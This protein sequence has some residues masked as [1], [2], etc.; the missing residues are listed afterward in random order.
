M[1][2]QTEHALAIDLC[3]NS[4]KHAGGAGRHNATAWGPCSIHIRAAAEIYA[5]LNGADERLHSTT[6]L[7]DDM[8][9]LA[10]RLGALR[11]TPNEPTWADLIHDLA[12]LR[13]QSNEGDSR[14][15]GLNHA[16]LPEGMWL[17]PGFCAG[18]DEERP[19]SMSELGCDC[20]ELCGMGPTCP[21]GILA[22]LPG[23][24][25]GRSRS[26]EKSEKPTLNP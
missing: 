25:C 1:S 2:E 7:P 14:T 10:Q 20:T 4:E 5:L 9:E 11:A 15:H 16:P 8:D 24:G 19:R 21:G 6:A 18:C 22:R 12:E 23:A 26:D 17:A 3:N 13:R